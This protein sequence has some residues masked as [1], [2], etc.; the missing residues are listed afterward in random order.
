MDNFNFY[1][2]RFFKSRFGSAM[3]AFERGF[4]VTGQAFNVN[5]GIQNANLQPGDLVRKLASGGLTLCDG[6]EGAGG[7][8]PPLG[9]VMHIGPYFDGT[10]MKPSN[11]LPSNVAYGTILERQSTIWYL[12]VESAIWEVDCDDAVTATT[13]AAYQLTGG[14]NADH[15]NAGAAGAAVETGAKPRLDISTVNTTNTLI[16][17]ILGIS[18]TQNNRD[19]SGN[20]VKL[21]VQPNV[22]QAPEVNATGI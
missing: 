7:A 5:G 9:V 19:Y 14:A 15:R 16:W 17:R 13:E 21:L 18:P 10:R 8:L 1:G 22:W 4:A 20:F 12:P 2:F 3:P 6:A 11:Q